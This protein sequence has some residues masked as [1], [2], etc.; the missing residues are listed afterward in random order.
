MSSMNSDS[1]NPLGL[2]PD[3]ERRLELL[4][5]Q[6]EIERRDREQAMWRKASSLPKAVTAGPE[7]ANRQQYLGGLPEP[8]KEITGLFAKLK[9][10]KF[11]E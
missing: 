5:Q 6:K 4:K 1:L 9:L 7:R 3:E 2:K 11:L 10:G 8:P